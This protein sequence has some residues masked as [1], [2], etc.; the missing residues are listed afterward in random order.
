MESSYLIQEQYVVARTTHAAKSVIVLK[1]WPCGPAL[2]TI[3]R[4]GAGVTAV[5]APVTIEAGIL[6]GRATTL[7]PVAT[8]AVAAFV[9][10]TT[11]DKP[12]PAA[13]EGTAADGALLSVATVDEA[14]PLGV[15]I[16]NMVC[17]T[18]TVGRPSAPVLVVVAAPART[19]PIG[20]AFAGELVRAGATTDEA[21]IM[22][23]EVTPE[24]AAVVIP[25]TAACVTEA[26]ALDAPKTGL[27]LAMAG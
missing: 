13:A 11:D 22:G 7:V 2:P 17:V 3:G 12:T 10:T 19:V 14:V 27:V 20:L 8:T 24:A 25:V 6:V 15:R 18:K 9:D 26:R 4:A 16:T 1:I 23:A 5:G 21:P